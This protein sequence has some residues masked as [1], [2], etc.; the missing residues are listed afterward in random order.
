MQ[1]LKKF[2][3]EDLKKFNPCYDPTEKMGGNGEHD[4]MSLID[5]GFMFY[6]LMWLFKQQKDYSIVSKKALNKMHE[7]V[8]RSN[9]HHNFV[10]AKKEN[11]DAALEKIASSDPVV[12][13]EGEE[14][15]EKIAINFTPFPKDLQHKVGLIKEAILH[16]AENDYLYD[17]A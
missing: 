7:L 5:C 2:T 17:E 3:A 6:D 10:N 12:K 9:E 4:L 14:Q 11:I 15:L 8:A 1:T 13:A 16:A